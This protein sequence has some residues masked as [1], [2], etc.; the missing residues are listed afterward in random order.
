MRH[1]HMGL[2]AW[3]RTY[4]E[5][6]LRVEYVWAGTVCESKNWRAGLQVFVMLSFDW[7]TQHFSVHLRRISLRLPWFIEESYWK[8]MNDE[9]LMMYI[10]YYKVC[11]IISLSLL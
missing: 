5:I 1:S 7:S 8:Y 10:I 11:T 9:S 4:T 3:W 6:R 2:L